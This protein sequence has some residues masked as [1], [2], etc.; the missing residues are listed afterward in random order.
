MSKNRTNDVTVDVCDF[1]DE[2]ASLLAWPVLIED[3]TFEITW[4]HTSGFPQTLFEPEEPAEVEVE[5][6]KLI[7]A[8]NN[9]LTESQTDEL[10]SFLDQYISEEDVEEKL[11]EVL[12]T[13]ADNEAEAE[14]EAEAEYE[15]ER[16]NA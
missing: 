11:W 3:V 16:R 14:A 8:G 10:N 6:W 12:G 1:N 15:E 4:R 2:I 13:E 9:S 5:E 7:A